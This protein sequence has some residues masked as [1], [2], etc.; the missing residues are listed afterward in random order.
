MYYLGLLYHWLAL[1]EFLLDNR[2]VIDVE[3]DEE[4][5]VHFVDMIYIIKIKS[6]F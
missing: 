3:W 1:V 4:E 6:I 5:R 2:N